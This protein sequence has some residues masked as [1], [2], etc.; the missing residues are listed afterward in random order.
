MTKP[1]KVLLVEDDPDDADRI[2][3]AL[4]GANSSRIE[5]EQVD[6]LDEATHRLETKSFDLI[7]LDLSLSD[8]SLSNVDSLDTI[9]QISHR[10]ATIPVVVLTESDDDKIA[11]DAIKLGAQDYLVKEQVSQPMMMRTIR[12][13]I[14]RHQLL[15]DLEK[16]ITALLHSEVR[17]HKMIEH[18]ADA[19]V[20][21]DNRGVVR[22]LNP[23]AETL[24]RTPSVQ[25]LN[26]K[27]AYPVVVGEAT[28]IS[29]T[30]SATNKTVAFAEM[31]V[32]EMI[33]EDDLAYLA[34]LRDITERKAVERS[35]HEHMCELQTR[36]EELDAFA[37]SAAHDLRNP[38]T[39]LI[40]FSK[41]LEEEYHLLSSD[42]IQSTLKTIVRTGQKMSHIID[43]LLT[44]AGLR[45][46]KTNLS[47]LDMAS[48]VCDA[49][50]NLTPLIES[51]NPEIVT[52]NEWP[53]VVGY[54][55]W[56]EQ[57]WTNYLSNGIKYG[58]SPPRLELGADVEPN[59][60]VR[61]WVSDNGAGLTFEDQQRL[62]KPF[63]RLEGQHKAVG[64]GLGL[65]IVKRIV[66]QLGGE[67]G[68]ASQG[69]PGQGSR[70][71]FTL[72]AQE[73]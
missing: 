29:I 48:I 4:T 62:F 52:P 59:G 63:S 16:Q 44:L 43:G 58:G 60:V 11:L 14:E 67:V 42:E 18:N 41:V 30:D 6:T 47:P 39:L 9:G 32:V 71:F 68:V 38:L 10:S 46:Q 31:R 69:I 21:I 49:K 70:F 66:E 40:G 28:E 13:A 50:R 61:F 37:H 1:I 36:N 19:I 3:A 54:R 5:C 7:L 51:Y 64:C 27:F 8:L 26:E 22:F 34:S 23:A 12:H 57:V 2:Q 45:N 33:W 24:L 17:F 65:S 25:I 72:T 55:P 20:I 35:L 56:I 73:Q 53:V 15:K